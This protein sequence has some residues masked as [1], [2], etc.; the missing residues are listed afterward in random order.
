MPAHK[1]RSI[2]PAGQNAKEFPLGDKTLAR[3]WNFY[4]REVE[5]PLDEGKEGN[6]VLISFRNKSWL[7]NAVRRGPAAA[8]PAQALLQ[9]RQK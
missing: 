5:R 1:F 6:W 8:G 4:P 3:E 7:I 9:R 2:S